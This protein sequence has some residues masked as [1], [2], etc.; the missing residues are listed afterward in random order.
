[1][2]EYYERILLF[3]QNII[4]IYVIDFKEKPQKAKAIGINLVLKSKL[5]TVFTFIQT[6]A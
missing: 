1:M 4:G 6:N 2:D 5:N 3:F